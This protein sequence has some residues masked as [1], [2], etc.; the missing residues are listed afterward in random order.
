MGCL[1]LLFFEIYENRI[2]IEQ[3]YEILLEIQMEYDF[4]GLKK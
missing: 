4:W 2:Q 1:K 3:I